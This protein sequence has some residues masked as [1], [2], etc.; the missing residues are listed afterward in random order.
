MN[1]A[2]FFHRLP[3]PAPETARTVEFDDRRSHHRLSCDQKV[4][5]GLRNGQKVVARLLDTSATGVRIEL[6]GAVHA[7]SQH[8][9]DIPFGGAAARFQLNIM[10]CR[11]TGR[12]RHEVGARLL[13]LRHQDSVRWFDHHDVA[14]HPSAV[15][16]RDE[17]MPVPEAPETLK[18]EAFG[19]APETRRLKET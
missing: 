10:W 16:I 18:M 17:R 6:P 14:K 5:V 7:G 19:K 1:L 8:F 13:F 11:H 4:V 12:G 3:R 15:D 2:S 9:V